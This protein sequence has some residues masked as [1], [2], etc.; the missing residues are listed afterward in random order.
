MP[1]NF[2]SVTQPNPPET[3][4]THPCFPDLATSDSHV[5]LV[6]FAIVGLGFLS[7]TISSLSSHGWGLHLIVP[8]YSW[9]QT[10]PDPQL[11]LFKSMFVIASRPADFMGCS[12]KA[13][14]CL[15]TQVPTFCKAVLLRIGGSSPYFQ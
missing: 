14:L 15:S 12:W 13:S 7:N 1:N 2:S 3:Q 10:L 5:A 4:S 9:G 11:P 8:W 6:A